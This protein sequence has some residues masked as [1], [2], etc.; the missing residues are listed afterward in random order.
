MSK[1]AN[2]KAKKRLLVIVIILASA[3]AVLIALSFLIDM[4][5]KEEIVKPDDIDF[6]FYEA[7]FNED[8]F[9][10]EEYLKLIEGG[11][12]S[13]KQNDTIIT[14]TRETAGELG[15]EVSFVVEMLYD[16]IYGQTKEYN[17]RFSSEYFKDHSPKDEFTMQMIYSAVIENVSTEYVT[18]DAGNYTK[19][20]FSLEYR[21][22]HNNGTFRRDIGNGARTQYITITNRSG[23]LL[24]D[25]IVTP[26]YK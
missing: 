14:I 10:N 20:I 25:D 6:D 12:V 3:L 24:I 19:Y 9:E 21:I 4:L 26:Y 23:K 17:A 1:N 7:D 13:Y 11:T 5:Q 15:S 2:A 18:T 8:I 16:V 22:Y